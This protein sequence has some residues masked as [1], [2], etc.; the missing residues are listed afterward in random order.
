MKL[1]DIAIRRPVFMTMVLAA[2]IVL[3]LVSYF[4]MPVDLF[5]NVEFPVVVVTTIYPGAS[6]EE[7]EDQVTS[8]LEEELG[9]IGGVEEI[10]SR[11]GEG[12]STIVLQFDLDLSVDDVN[13]EIREKVGLLRNRL[14]DGIEEPII[15]RFSPSDNPV[16][17]FG[18][19]D[20]MDGYT[21]VELRQLCR[22]QYP[23]TASACTRCRHCRGEWRRS[24]RDT[25]QPRYAG[26]PGPPHLATAGDRGVAHGKPEHSRRLY[27]RRQP[28][29]T[30]AH[31]GEFRHL[32]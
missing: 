13:Q 24:A 16:L 20:T 1:W 23:G 10:N 18:V 6:P 9:A 19:T 2:G 31:T 15:R 21:P 12:I 25:G 5:P 11:S 32:G 28:G 17:L 29:T 4:R 27:C 7:M 3:G 30:P 14:P 8:I 22:G 26:P